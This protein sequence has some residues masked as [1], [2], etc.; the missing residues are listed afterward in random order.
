MVIKKQLPN[1]SIIIPYKKGYASDAIRGRDATERPWNLQQIIIELAAQFPH[2][3]LLDVGCGTC[4]RII[5]LSDYFEKI[6]GIDPSEN[7]QEVALEN[8]TNSHKNNINL[9]RGH[10]G[11]LPFQD[12]SFSIVTSMMSFWDEREMFR[13]LQPGGYAIVE[14]SGNRDK[15]NIKRLFGQDEQ[16]WRGQRIDFDDGELQKVYQQRFSAYFKDIKIREGSWR[17]HYTYEGIIA[18]LTETSTVRKFDKIADSKA[19]AEIVNKFTT[20]NG[21]ESEQQR[22]LIIAKKDQTSKI[23]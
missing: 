18:L 7:I 8:I 4:A 3:T 6:Y 1:P 5:P 20:E 16:G 21:I 23:S 11:Q 14:T 9:V 15:E 17:T 12:A 22:I 2:P 19:L 10:A 13:V